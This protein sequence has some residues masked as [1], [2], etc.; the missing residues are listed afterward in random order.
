MRNI[1]RN[2]YIKDYVYDK[3]TGEIIRQKI[4]LPDYKGKEFIIEVQR[5]YFDGKETGI[6]FELDLFELKQAYKEN[7]L[8]G[9][10]KELVATLNESTDNNV[11]VFVRFN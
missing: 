9:Q 5:T 10:L 7:K 1:Q 4:I 3:Q 2:E 8:S 11:I 6:H